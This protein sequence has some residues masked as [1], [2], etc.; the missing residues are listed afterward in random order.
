MEDRL[1]G[2]RRQMAAKKLDALLVTSAANVRY[3]SGFPNEDG[4][5]VVT[6]DKA[7]I[8]TDF[9]YLGL[10]PSIRPGFEL[11]EV[12]GARP[13]A[14]AVA[15]VARSEGA[16]RLGFDDSH[17]NYATYRG[18]RRAVAEGRKSAVR[19]VVA[20]GL[21][22]NLRAVKDSQELAAIERAVAIAD[23]AMADVLALL[24]ST[25]PATMSER[26]V[27]WILERSMRE[28]GA[29]AIAFDVAVASGPNS[30]VPHHSSSDR[31][32]SA[33]EPIWIDMG[34]RVDGYCSDV[35]RS[36]C[37]GEPDGR[38]RQIH[39]IVLEAQLAAEK[40]IR[41]GIAGRIPHE[42]AREI[43]GAAGYGEAFRHG[44]GHGIGLQVHESPFMGSAR[45]ASAELRAGNVVS[46]EPG[47]Y[48]EGWGGVRIEDLVTVTDEGCRVLTR[49]PK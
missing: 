1:T 27:A 3:L 6:A 7:F 34:A 12:T 9:R 38:F 13:L 31:L 47:I 25:A 20:G 41:A 15:E 36:F 19:L 23:Q 18:L 43:I 30:S 2:V 48:L 24:R 35:T 39:A 26:Q 10:L 33:G 21:V 44:T 4:T 37:L 16:R 8:A 29:E 49:A 46:V 40:A 5:L 28:L 14:Q 32:L 45:R 17:V 22:E 11:I 42:A